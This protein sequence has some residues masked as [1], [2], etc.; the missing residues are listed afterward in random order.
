[1]PAEDV[2]AILTL[3]QP[4]KIRD[5]DEELHVF[6]EKKIAKQFQVHFFSSFLY[7]YVL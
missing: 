3:L 6:L 1:M 7:D 2:N 4:L 5:N